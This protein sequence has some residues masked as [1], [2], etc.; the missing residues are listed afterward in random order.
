M[1]RNFCAALVIVVI[2]SLGACGKKAI[3][4][5]TITDLFDGE[6]RVWF[7]IDGHYSDELSYDDEVDMV[8]VTKNK[9][10]TQIYYNLVGSGIHPKEIVCDD[11]I[12]PFTCERFILG[13]FT[14]LSNAE[15]IEKVKA[16]YADASLTY[17]CTRNYGSYSNSFS[18]KQIELPYTIKY[19]GDLDN[20]GNNLQNETISFAD[21]DLSVNAKIAIGLQ[22]SPFFEAIYCGNF[23]V[24]SIIGPTE[25]KDK[26]YVGLKDDRNERNKIITVNNYANF[27]SIGYDNPQG[28]SE[29]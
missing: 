8:F 6:E 20:S 12:N 14:G 22:V 16:A 10:V 25:I 21:H 1:K 28:I 23:D 24:G 9:K 4:P 5:T 13:D 17:N 15:I 18:I 2:L 26:V 29:W 7:Y 3:T 11:E 27:E 19:N